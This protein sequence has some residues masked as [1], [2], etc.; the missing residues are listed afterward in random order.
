[1]KKIFC[2][3]LMILFF[4]SGN[5][6]A[7]DIQ[8][9]IIESTSESIGINDFFE[10]TEEYLK[11]YSD[12]DVKDIFL[13][14]LKNGE[15][16]E[17]KILDK[18]KTTLSTNI[19]EKLEI[20]IKI[21]IM[22]IIHAILRSISEE[23]ESSATSKIVF[24]LE[25]LIIASMIVSEFSDIALQVKNTINTFA[26]FMYSFIPILIV[27]VTSTGGIVTGSVTQKIIIFLITFIASCIK[28]FILPILFISI[29][30]GIVGNFS[31]KIQIKGLSKYLNSFIFWFFGIVLTLFVT[32]INLEGSLS[33]SVDGITAK[34]AKAA[35]SSLVPVVGKILGDATDTVIGSIH[36]LKNGFGIIRDCYYGNNSIKTTFRCDYIYASFWRTC[37]Y[38][39]NNF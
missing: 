37:S 4:L 34:T 23:M 28:N 8:N 1:M 30:L 27:L 24:Y 2:M 22:L 38:I 11:E 15:I 10:K 14:T 26:S 19:K 7:S 32:L 25:Y 12:L 5:V 13:D 39:G 29:L 31:D 6:S 21:L 33:S 35:V 9:E 3:G 18:I 17:T 20:I 36:V 16:E